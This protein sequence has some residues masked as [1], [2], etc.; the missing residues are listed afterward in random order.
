MRASAAR[1]ASR[2]KAERV[3]KPGSDATRV[4]VRSAR[5]TGTGT[6]VLT[7]PGA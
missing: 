7:R 3:S 6:R 1:K 5:E 4:Q 2:V